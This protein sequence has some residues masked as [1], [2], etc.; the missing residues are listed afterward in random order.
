MSISLEKNHSL[1]SS[2][3]KTEAEFEANS[4]SKSLIMMSMKR[5]SYD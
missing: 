1:Q 5:W 3:G 2:K 4:Y